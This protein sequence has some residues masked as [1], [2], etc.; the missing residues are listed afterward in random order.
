LKEKLMKMISVKPKV[1]PVKRA[2]GGGK[3]LLFFLVIAALFAFDMFISKPVT[4]A[5]TAALVVAEGAVQNPV[6]NLVVSKQSAEQKMNYSE[7]MN[8][9]KDKKIQTAEMKDGEV[10]GLTTDG[11]KYKAT[12]LYDAETLQKLNDAGVKIT[13]DNAKS[14]WESLGTWLPILL[15][16]LFIYLLFKSTRMA[17]GGGIGGMMQMGAHQVNSVPND[18]VITFK[19]VAG[20]DDAKREVEELVDFLKSPA[21]FTKLGARLPRGVL[22][23]GEPGTGKTLLARAVAGEAKVPFFSSSGSEFSGI[24]VGLGVSKVRELFKLAKSNAPCILFIDEIDAIGQKRGKGTMSDHDRE[25]TLNQLLIEMDGFDANSGVIV[26]GATNRPDILDAALLRPGRFDRQV[27]IDL[28]NMQGRK[29]ILKIYAN[30]LQLENNVDLEIIARGTPGFS[31]AELA[32][33]M[34]EAAILAVRRKSNSVSNNDLDLARD[35]I[36]MGPEK[37]MKM[38][39]AD[40]KLAAIHESGHAFMTMHYKGIADPI[41]KATIIP[42]GRA[43]GMVQHL[44][45]DDK[46]SMNISEIRANLSIYLAGRASEE[47]FLGKD[48]ITTGASSDISQATNLARHAIAEAG[49]S[50][51]LGMIAV[52]ETVG[53]WGITGRRENV[54]DKTAEILDNEVR[55]MLDAAYRDAK[56]VLTKN[57]AKVKKLSDELLKRETLTASEIEKIL[58]KK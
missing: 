35:K 28:P 56:S 17:H 37:A 40:K 15:M 32:N 52:R 1:Q 43:L 27:Y 55:A 47:V 36:L 20:I 11:Q 50:P 49:L 14:F 19:D 48:K 33:L 10:S 3:Y 8:A 53:G 25:Q 54:S 31:G 29:E 6:Q 46:H 13:I 16:I 4:V 41:L 12:V 18:K 45:I 39:D 5:P 30:K 42:R 21:E 2:S 57:K 44:P 24:L 51:K 9:A 38:S 7:F 58:K 34:N 23:S 22:L 26:I